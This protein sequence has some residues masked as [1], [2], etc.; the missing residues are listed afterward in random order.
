[1]SVDSPEGGGQEGR[2]EPWRSSVKGIPTSW[3]ARR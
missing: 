3:A 1:M 2:D